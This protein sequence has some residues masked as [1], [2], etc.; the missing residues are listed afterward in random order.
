MKLR[1]REWRKRRRRTQPKLAAAFGVSQGMISKVERGETDPGAEIL[2][3]LAAALEVPVTGLVDGEF[4]GKLAGAAEKASVAQITEVALALDPADQMLRSP[5]CEDCRKPVNVDQ[6]LQR[7]HVA[8]GQPRQQPPDIRRRE[9]AP[10]RRNEPRQ[11][12][13]ARL[14]VRLLPGLAG[15]RQ[16]LGV[17]ASESKERARSALQAPPPPVRHHEHAACRNSA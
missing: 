17:D 14:A 15:L 9:T 2:F 12:R 3:R 4:G 10:R 13:H 1:I 6:R 11:A 5:S 7:G 16:A 8:R